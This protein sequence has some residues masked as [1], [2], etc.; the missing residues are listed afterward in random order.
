MHR[1]TWVCLAVVLAGLFA[2]PALARDLGLDDLVGHW[3]GEGSDYTFS[4]R[5][6]P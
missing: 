1:S 5:S 2:S 6:Y 3:C 4:K